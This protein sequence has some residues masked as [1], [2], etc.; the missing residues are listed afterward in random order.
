[1]QADRDELLGTESLH[2]FAHQ[3][4]DGKITLLDLVMDK[5]RGDRHSELDR[6]LL[7][8]GKPR[9]LLVVQAARRFGEAIEHA[10]EPLALVVVL[11]IVRERR[12]GAAAGMVP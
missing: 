4:F 2:R 8:L 6:G 5:M 10:P 11:A 1:M 3:G 9:A 12:T 7:H